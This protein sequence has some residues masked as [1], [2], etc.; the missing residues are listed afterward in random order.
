MSIGAKQNLL[1]EAETRLGTILTAETLARVMPALSESL[2]GYDVEQIAAQDADYDLLDAFIAAKLVEGRSEKTIERYTY[3]IRR[4]LE[5]THTTTRQ[6]TVYHIRAYFMSEKERG[7]SNSTLDGIRSVLSSFF[8]WLQKEGLIERNPCG[9]FGTIKCAKVVR[10]PYTA[11]DIERL[12]EGCKT[13]RDRA[14]VALLLSTGCRISEVCGLNIEDIRFSALE[15]TVLGKGNKERIVY[16]DSVCAMLLNRYLSKR[17]DD[18][19]ALFVGKRGERLEPGGVRIMLKQL[20]KKTGV[21]NVHPHRF[22]RTLA[23]NL[24]AR[25]MAIQEVAAILG[26]ERIDTTMKYVYLDKS[27]V[28]NS[29]RKYA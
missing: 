17:K 29:Y 6:A 3:T 21:E 13:A 20:E 26:H 1:R 19:P 4:F 8:G 12:K 22:R 5:D 24:I 9:N 7:V 18:N 2:T 16:L 11:E 15:C 27:A 25:G 23:T 10:K 14:L 28:K